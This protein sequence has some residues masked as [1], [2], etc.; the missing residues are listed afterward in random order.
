MNAAQR[1]KAII[2][3]LQAATGPLSATALAGRFAVSRQIIVGDVA[4]LRAAGYQVASTPRGYLLQRAETGLRKT[5]AC[6]HRPDQMVDELNIIVDNGCTVLDVVV[7]H[8]VYGQLIGSL[9]LRSRYDISQFAQRV[10]QEAAAPLSSL[11][12][13]IHLHTLLC[14]DENAYARVCT[15]LQQAGILLADT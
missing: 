11:T 1:R 7:E 4:L 12:D 14:P 2:D 15:A 6:L 13:G 5:I 3:A 9:M 10:A 8:P